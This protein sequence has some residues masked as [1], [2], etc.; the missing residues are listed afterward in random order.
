MSGL[1]PDDLFEISIVIKDGL[2]LQLVAEQSLRSGLLLPLGVEII[3]IVAA[4]A[5]PNQVRRI[6]SIWPP[7]G[8]SRCMKR[9]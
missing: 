2:R 4:Q 6:S 8:R 5:K 7:F 3:N 9:A 1:A